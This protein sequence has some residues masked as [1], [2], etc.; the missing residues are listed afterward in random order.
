MKR[1]TTKIKEDLSA[2]TFIRNPLVWKDGILPD[3]FREPKEIEEWNDEIM[4]E[5]YLEDS[6][7]DNKVE[8]DE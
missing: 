3:E 5:R 4:L 6:G 1:K 2:L 7:E 8:D